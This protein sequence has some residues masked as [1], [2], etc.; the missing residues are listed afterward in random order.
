M[1]K[2]QVD[3]KKAYDFNN[4]IC[5]E[6]RKIC[7][8]FMGIS[9]ITSFTYHKIYLDGNAISLCT[10]KEALKYYLQYV[11]EKG[12]FFQKHLK[13][14]PLGEP[15]YFL[16]PNKIENSLQE[17]MCQIKLW[18]GFNVYIKRDNYIENFVLTTN[19]NN[20]EVQ[21]FCIN[22]LSLINYFVAYFRQKTCNLTA[23][24]SKKDMAFF[25]N[26]ERWDNGS[27]KSKKLH[28]CD[29]ERFPFFLADRAI[30]LTKREATCL[31]YIGYGYSIKEIA[32]KLTISPRTIETY[33]ENIKIKSGLHFK[34]EIVQLLRSVDNNLVKDLILL[35]EKDGK[36]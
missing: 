16:W 9:G 24:L 36:S 8:P 22:N 11:G 20:T 2:N 35:S 19:P 26:I 7:Q 15:Y 12:L 25:N 5:D 30:Y 6:L 3:N 32:I 1:I 34:S 29:L 13:D 4:S 14:I 17:I 18:N 28:I 31:S 33:I 23:K 21:G 10:E 27:S